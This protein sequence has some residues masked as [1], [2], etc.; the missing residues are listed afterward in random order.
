M[1]GWNSL[2]DCQELVAHL[3][4]RLSVRHIADLQAAWRLAP[5]KAL[6]LAGDP[7]NTI[8]RYTRQK[9]YYVRG[10]DWN[11]LVLLK[12]RPNHHSGQSSQIGDPLLPA[13]VKARRRHDF[14]PI[15]PFQFRLDMHLTRSTVFRNGPSQ[16]EPVGIITKI[17]RLRSGQPIKACHV[18]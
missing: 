13:S 11:K 10:S 18:G 5:S 4:S 8:L 12:S 1:L 7:Q 6:E 16:G 14:G 17:F 3:W 15:L 2:V 9:S